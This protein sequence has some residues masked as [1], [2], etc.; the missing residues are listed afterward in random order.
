MSF[1]ILLD[2]DDVEHG[3]DGLW[4]DYVS[5]FRLQRCVYCAASPHWLVFP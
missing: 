3:R 5:F 4:R 1:N 2:A